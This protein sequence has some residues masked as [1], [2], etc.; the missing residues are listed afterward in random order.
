M[1]GA[2]NSIVGQTEIYPRYVIVEGSGTGSKYIIA[3][4][5]VPEAISC[6][7]VLVVI[8]VLALVLVL[9]LVLHFC[10]APTPP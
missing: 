9:F 6:A 5:F 3:L 2:Y 1:L 7:I 4:E 10:V 8:V